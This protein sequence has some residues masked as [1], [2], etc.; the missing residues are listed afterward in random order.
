MLTPIR[1]WNASEGNRDNH[2]PS[3]VEVVD[4]IPAMSESGVLYRVKTLGG[5]YRDLD[6]AWFENK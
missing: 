5:K 4:V 3:Q 1:D 6:A 2:L